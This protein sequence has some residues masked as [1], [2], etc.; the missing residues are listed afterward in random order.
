MWPIVAVESVIASLQ[1]DEHDMEAYALAN[2]L[3]AAAAAQLKANQSEFD[4]I[5]ASSMEEECQRSKL[6][7]KDGSPVNLNGLRI[8]FFLH[9]YHE[10]QQPGGVKSL[11][12][13]REAI[14]LAQ[15]LGLH[16]ER[17]YITLSD[18]DQQISR[19]ILWLLFVTER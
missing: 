11:L 15:I 9:I 18:P 19:R 17:T 6:L 7:I 12:Y 2:A 10:N 4:A 1:R 14:T 5:T 16:R 8:A 3:G 13:L